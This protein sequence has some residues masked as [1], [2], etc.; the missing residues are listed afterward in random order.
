MTLP[1]LGASTTAVVWLAI[2]LVTLLAVVGMLVALVRHGLLIGRAVRRMSDEVTPITSEI[3][4][5]NAASQARR[6]A[7]RG[8][9][10][11]SR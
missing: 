10:S 4:A 8:R 1:L 6:T 2:G 5:M 9:T 11:R 3:Q 7:L